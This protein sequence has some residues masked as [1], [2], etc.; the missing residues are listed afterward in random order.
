V[1][2]PLDARTRFLVDHGLAEGPAPAPP[3]RSLTILRRQGRIGTGMGRSTRWAAVD[4]L[5]RQGTE[6]LS[7]VRCEA[8]TPDGVCVTDDTGTRLIPADSVVVAIGQ[9]PHATLLP[10]LAETGVPV[11]LAGG[12]AGATRLNATR[13][14]EDGLRAAHSLGR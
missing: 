8:I 3:S 9:E 13:A 14:F 4:A 10:L 11:R 2:S 7:G 12:S 5:R 6:L 1:P